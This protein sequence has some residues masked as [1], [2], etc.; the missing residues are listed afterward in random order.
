MKSNP[1]LQNGILL[2]LFIITI[3]LPINFANGEI[4]S[5]IDFKN[6]DVSKP[7]EFIKWYNSGENKTGYLEYEKFLKSQ[8]AYGIFPTWQLLLSDTEYISPLCQSN[9][10][11]LPPKKYWKNSVKTIKFIEKNIIPKIGKVKIVS[12]FR[13]S[14]FN[15]CI[16]GAP[17]SKHLEFGAFDLV[18]VEHDANDRLFNNLCEIW[19]KTNNNFG[20]G[21]GAYWDKLGKIS[22]P[23]GRFHIDTFGKRTWGLNYKSETSFC[24][25]SK[26]K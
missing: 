18:S 12:G 19:R 4:L 1:I 3:A 15:K 25:N 13:P 6:S 8:N 22:N 9:K 16:G 2:I 21:L 11:V 5:A 17:K 10:F 24:I 20:F 14:D 26:Q 7:A 23:S